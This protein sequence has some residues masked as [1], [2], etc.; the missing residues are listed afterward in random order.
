V[1]G[2]A[3]DGHVKFTTLGSSGL[4][5]SVLALGGSGLG[6]SIDETTSVRLVRQAADSGINLFDTADNYG[7]GVSE[8]TLGRAV[9]GIRDQVVLATKGRWPTGPGTND[10]GNSRI[11]LRAAVEA[12]LRRLGTDHIDLYQLH[13]PDPATPL[14]ET[15]A[16]LDQLVSAGKI[17][18]AGTS[19]F[20]GWQIMDAH[21]ESTRHRQVKLV[22]TQAPYS[23]LQREA[24]QELLP[25]ARR[26]GVGFIACLTLARGLL[27]GAFSHDTDPAALTGRK[28]AFL[29]KRNQSR[30]TVV[31][32]FASE[33]GLSTA[34]VALAA[35]IGHPDV[36]CALAGASSEQQL[37]ANVEAIG[38]RLPAVVRDELLAELRRVDA[39]HD[40][41]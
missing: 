18:Y 19:N 23:L 21:W 37:L 25:A 2:V 38:T 36:H 12:S 14:E 24:E 30:M 40:Q 34:Q 35:V 39:A 6:T 17:L 16:V 29:T 28:R 15:V 11:H 1:A 27:A 5:V 22:S 20:A 10:R 13:A 4:R 33:H 31:S 32:T 8:E 3:A 26:C 41:A 7:D 9:K